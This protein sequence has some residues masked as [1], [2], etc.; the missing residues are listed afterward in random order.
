MLSLNP[1]MSQFRFIIP[2]EFLPEEIKDKYREVI[3]REPSVLYDPI[4]YLNE[5]IKGVSF[6]GISELI[7]EQAQTSTNTNKMGREPARMNVTTTI[8]NPLELIDNTITVTFR[9]NRG[10]VN[11]FMVYEM[12]FHR[13]MK[14]KNYRDGDEFM[15]QLLD[16]NGKVIS[17]VTFYQCHPEGMDGLN[18]SYSNTDPE[19]AEFSIVFRFNNINFTIEP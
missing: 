4:D 5:S 16:Q 9:C 3:N 8:K 17:V 2:T 1:K 14:T 15:L 6:P 12:L 18:F 13:L 7:Q 11:Y 19:E 10:F